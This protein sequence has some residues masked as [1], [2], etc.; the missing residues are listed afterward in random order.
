MSIPV[1]IVGAG[2]H[3]LVVADALLAAG[4]E[5]LGFTDADPAKQGGMLCGRKILGPDAEVLASRNPSLVHLA[6]GIGGVGGEGSALRRRVQEHLERQG[7]RFVGV[8]HP[9]AIISPF[10]GV[11][12]TAQLLA[13]AVVQPMARVGEGCIVNTGAVIEHDV[14]VG[15]Y[16]HIAPGA[17]VCGAVALGENVHVGAGAVVRQGVVVGDNALIGAGAAV[18]ADAGRGDCLVGV[19]A[20][21]KKLN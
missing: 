7:W 18:V 11:A 12:E 8:R 17:V 19:P 1:I 5:V 15:A 16:A 2:G 9:S 6:N 13:R 14:Q 10:A 4:H 21:H 20:R 3:G